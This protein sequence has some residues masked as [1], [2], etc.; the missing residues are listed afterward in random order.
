MYGIGE[1]VVHSGDGVCVVKDI[2]QMCFDGT[3][4]KEYYC[5]ETINKKGTLCFVSVSNEKSLRPVID[6]AEFE[7]LWNNVDDIDI[8]DSANVKVRTLLYKE[9]LKKRTCE[10]YIR[11]LKT[12]DENCRN[13]KNTGKSISATDERFWNDAFENLKSEM[14]VVLEISTDEAEER[15]NNK[16]RIENTEKA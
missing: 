15:I 12:I 1:Y 8:I 9:E 10:S 5:L 16:F 3:N 14:S 13:R 6:K 2:A 11:L 7:T 4:T